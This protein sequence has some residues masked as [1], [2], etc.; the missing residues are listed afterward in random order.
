MLQGC[1][2]TCGLCVPG[3]TTLASTTPFVGTTTEPTIV[4]PGDESALHLVV[5]IVARSNLV[6]DAIAQQLERLA[7]DPQ[8]LLITLYEELEQEGFS[9]AAIPGEG[10]RPRVHS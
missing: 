4:W 9:G 7:T 5:E 8:Q 10:V 3:T 6:R 1:R 2:V